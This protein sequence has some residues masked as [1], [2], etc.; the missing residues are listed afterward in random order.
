[1]AENGNNGSALVDH[2]DLINEGLLQFTKE[3]GLSI[4]D[5][6]ESFTDFCSMSGWVRSFW[7]FEIYCKRYYR[8][9]LDKNYRNMQ[10][11][12]NYFSDLTD[13]DY[14]NMQFYDDYFS[15]LTVFDS[16]PGS[17]TDSDDSSS[18]SDISGVTKIRFVFDED[19]LLDINLLFIDN[20]IEGV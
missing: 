9:F 2:K 18:N 10:F 8:Y 5:L 12:D 19:I 20:S 6:Y 7:N 17:D 16:D 15:N 13:F 11:Y 1:M 3:H 4:D 14:R